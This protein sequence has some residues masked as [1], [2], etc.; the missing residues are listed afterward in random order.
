MSPVAG[1][2]S[3]SHCLG[4]RT[5]PVSHRDKLG[6][7]EGTGGDSI[8]TRVR[9]RATREG[10][11]PERGGLAPTGEAASSGSCLALAVL[12]WR[13]ASAETRHPWATF[14]TFCQLRIAPTG[15]VSVIDPPGAEEGNETRQ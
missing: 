7:G 9:V 12:A 14:S 4:Q 10:N 1:T 13:A 8:I 15:R 11:R 3:L 2:F 5:P 6:S